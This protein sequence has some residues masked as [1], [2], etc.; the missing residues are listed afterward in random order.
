MAKRIVRFIMNVL[1]C[2]AESKYACLS[3]CYDYEG[4]NI[5]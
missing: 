4:H 3:G 1:A 5:R 2:S